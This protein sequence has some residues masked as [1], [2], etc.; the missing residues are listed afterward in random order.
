M[1]RSRTPTWLTASTLL[2]EHL[3]AHHHVE[4]KLSVTHHAHEPEPLPIEKLPIGEWTLTGGTTIMGL[5]ASLWPD[6]FHRFLG[7]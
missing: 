6:V 7:L 4:I 2:L 3:R 5:A 1:P